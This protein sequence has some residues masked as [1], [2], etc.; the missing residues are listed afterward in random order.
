MPYEVIAAYDH[1][2]ATM[3]SDLA[4]GCVHS[5]TSFDA[6]DAAQSRVWGGW[7][8]GA[9]CGLLF[10]LDPSAIYRP[11]HPQATPLFKLTESLYEAVKGQWD[12]R[13]ET[14]YGYW[15]GLS[16]EAVARHLACGVLAHGFARARCGACGAEFLIAFSRKG[17]GCAHAAQPSP[18]LRSRP[19]STRTCSNRWVTHSGFSLSPRCFALSPTIRKETEQPSVPREKAPQRA[20]GWWPSTARWR[21]GGCVTAR[22][23]SVAS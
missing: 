15:H 1:P 17:R 3:P 8:T 7:M 16:D 4:A 11:R 21:P 13:F 20:W 19:S 9:P 22:A 6:Q 23:G 5:V 12:E 14:R 10:V 18:L 2:G